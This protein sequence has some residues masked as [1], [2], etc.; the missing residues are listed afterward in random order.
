MKQYLLVN[1]SEGNGL[2]Y[3]FLRSLAGYSIIML[4]ASGAN[5]LML[6]ISGVRPKMVPEPFDYFLIPST[7]LMTLPPSG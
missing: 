2:L 4:A 1:A 3:L 6:C 7:A 5:Y